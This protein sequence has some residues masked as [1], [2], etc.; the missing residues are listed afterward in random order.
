MA[1]FWRERN[2]PK[3]KIWVKGLWRPI[4]HQPAHFTQLPSFSHLLVLSNILSKVLSNIS[5]FNSSKGITHLSPSG[6]WIGPYNMKFIGPF[7]RPTLS[8]ISNLGPTSVPMDF[9]LQGPLY[10]PLCKVGLKLRPTSSPSG[11]NSKWALI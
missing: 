6:T 1:A 3:A 8:R 10:S 9:I 5:S 4:S 11:I 2:G 7:G